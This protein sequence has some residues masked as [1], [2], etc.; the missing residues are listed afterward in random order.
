MDNTN[1]PY[2]IAKMTG[3]KDHEYVLMWN[4]EI[5]FS[6]K[7]HEGIY[8]LTVYRDFVWDGGSIPRIGWTALGITPHGSICCEVAFLVHDV[9]YA[10][11]L[12]P[13]HICDEILCDL[14]LAYG[15]TDF[16]VQPIYA[17]VVAFG[18]SV[19]NDC[20]NKKAMQ[21]FVKLEHIAK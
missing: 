3:R 16:I 13:R 11:Q 14:I 10:T 8:K 6:L 7:G 21:D 2:P 20:P 15:G 1:K 18:D 12:L 5:E 4:F 17:S 19:Y 9:L